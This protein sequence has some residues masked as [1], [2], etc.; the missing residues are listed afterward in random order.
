[1]NANRHLTQLRR[2]DN[3]PMSPTPPV[4]HTASSVLAVIPHHDCEEW[5]G[6]AI[7][8]LVSQTR[9]P[10]G[11]VVVDDAEG[12]P[13]AE[14]VSRFPDVTLLK[15]AGRRNVGP[16]RI[17]QQVVNETRYDGYL[18]QDADDWSMPD[19]LQRLL[20]VAEQTNAELVG[21]QE[22]RVLCQHGEAV[23][24]TYPLD[25]NAA[26]Q[27]H[28]TS[29]PLLHPTS[30]VSRDL[31]MRVGGFATGLRFGGDSEFLRRAMHVARGVNVP[32][33][34]Y[35]RRIRTGSLTTAADTGMQSPNRFVLLATLHARARANADLVARGLPPVLEALAVAPRVRLSHACGPPLR[36]RSDHG[37]RQPAPALVVAP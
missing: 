3:R 7:E 29:F 4:L 1:M 18:W 33:F 5:L 19:R 14:I 13:P 25:V 23:P 6:D 10:D 36:R 27:E 22:L 32:Q 31:M 17:S 16:Y 2:K 21:S 12:D 8:S 34:C 20:E 11:I 30:V 26:L 28:P 15:V 37:S 9:T 24:F 35:L